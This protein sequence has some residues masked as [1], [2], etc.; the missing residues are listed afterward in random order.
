MIEHRRTG[1]LAKFKD[2]ADLAEGIRWT[3]N[4]ADQQSLHKACLHKVAH[5]YSQQ[6]VSMR[7]IEVYNEMIAL[8]RY[9]V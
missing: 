6:S 1:Y 2:T 3:L 9:I 5:D 8:K 4:E 7:Y